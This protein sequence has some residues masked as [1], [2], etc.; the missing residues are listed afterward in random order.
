MTNIL[1]AGG[2]SILYV[3]DIGDYWLYETLLEKIVPATVVYHP[4]SV[5]GE[6]HCPPE[7]VGGASGYESF[8]KIALIRKTRNMRTRSNGHEVDSSRSSSVW[9]Q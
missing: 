4:V 6:R 3:Y 9:R 1:K 2:D 7:D 5:A 8:L